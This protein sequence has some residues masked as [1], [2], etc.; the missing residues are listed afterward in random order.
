MEPVEEVGKSAAQPTAVI[1]AVGHAAGIGSH[2]RSDV[3]IYNPSTS[4]AAFDLLF[5][6]SRTDG[7]QEGRRST[8]TVD[9]NPE[10]LPVEIRERIADAL[11]GL[12]YGTIEIQ[13]HDARVV[14][15][16]RTEKIILEAANDRSK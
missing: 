14:R 7:T 4:A 12:R 13:V 1:P 5:T 15:I 9:R 2:W 11:R 6:P 3:R 10:P 8:M 16:T